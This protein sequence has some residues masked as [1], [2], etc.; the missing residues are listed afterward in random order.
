MQQDTTTEMHINKY[1]E[2]PIHKSSMIA[3]TG[4]TEFPMFYQMMSGQAYTP[5]ISSLSFLQKKC[6]KSNQNYPIFQ[7]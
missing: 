7:M 5:V 3:L 2:R 6:L 4:G 1:T